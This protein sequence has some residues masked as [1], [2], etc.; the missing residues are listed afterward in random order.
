MIDSGDPVLLLDYDSS[1]TQTRA[2]YKAPEAMPS[3]QKESLT[4]QAP[5]LN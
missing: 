1:L 4:K 5:S 2:D 3:T